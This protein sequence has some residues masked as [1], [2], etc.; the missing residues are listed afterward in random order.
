MSKC[1]QAYGIKV[2]EPTWLELDSTKYKDWIS[3]VETY[4]PK[5][6]QIVVF[7]LD[8]YIDSLYKQL[9]IH[10]LCDYGYKSSVIKPESLTKNAMSVGSKFLLQINYKIGGST[11]KV[12]FDKYVKV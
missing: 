8:K 2:A 3:E 9:K 12:E 11:Y 5:K 4:N 10:S 6:F 7:M 1:S